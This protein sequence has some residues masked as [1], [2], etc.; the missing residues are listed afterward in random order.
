LK[1]DDYMDEF[2]CKIAN[3]DE[4]NIKWDYEIEHNKDEKE[5]WITWK[6]DNID[7]FKKGFIIPYYGILNGKIITE[8]TALIDRNVLK[9]ISDLIDD[10]TAYLM[11]FRTI[12]EYQGKGYFSKLF[13]YIV[14]DLKKKGYKRLTIGVE[15]TEIKNKTIYFNYGF[16]NFVRRSQEKYPDGTIIDVEYYYK[17]LEK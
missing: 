1:D 3:E 17:E 16:T 2:I 10:K 13:K 8:G 5:N 11:A 6:K 12:E 9:D 7:R 14:D 15:P 4:M